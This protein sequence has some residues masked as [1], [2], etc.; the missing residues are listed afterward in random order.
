VSAIGGARS[1]AVLAKRAAAA[2]SSGGG[3]LAFGWRKEKRERAQLG[4]KEE[5]GWLIG[6]ARLDQK[7]ATTAGWAVHAGKW[8][9]REKWKRGENKGWAARDVWAEIR[10]GRRAKQK[11]V[12]E[13]LIQGNGIQT[14]SFEYFQTQIWTRFKIDWIQINFQNFSNLEIWN[15]V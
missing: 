6:W 3:G 15:L 4:R 10:S 14:K 12:F 2:R 11:I 1:A 7:W 13:F 9:G 5:V 8:I